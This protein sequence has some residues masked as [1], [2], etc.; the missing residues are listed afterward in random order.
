VWKSA[1]A[2]A[3]VVV[4]GLACRDKGA[5]EQTATGS[6]SAHVE[7]AAAQ[8]VAT[9]AE[10]SGTVE[11]RRKGEVRW[12]RVDVGATFRER[13]WVRTGANSFARLR[14]AT[15]GFLDLGENT[16]VLV[17][18]SVS[19]ESGSVV[20]IAEGAEPIRVNAGDGSEAR[21]AA[22]PGGP[23]EFRLTPSGTG[24]EI[25]VIKG[26]LEV[27]TKDGKRIVAA[28]QATDV[29]QQ[30]TSEVVQL[31]PFP[32]S[33]SPGVDARFKFGAG[34]RIPLAWTEVPGAAH[35]HLQIARDTE[36]HNLVMTSETA[37]T[38]GS[39]SPDAE[40]LYVWR[41]AARDASGR[42]G[43][44]GFAR[45]LYCESGE[46]RDLLIGPRD[47]FKIEF[48]S[49]PPAV[50]F[51]W[52]SMGDIK[53]YKLIIERAPGSE[54]V[55][56]TVTAAQQLSVTLDEGTYVWG[57]YAIKPND[58]EEPIFLTLRLLTIHK[59]QGPKIHTEVH[60]N[61]PRP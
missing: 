19:V 11:V 2:L 57:V 35:Y 39:F 52:R 45:R 30:R 9:S 50:E 24:L 3:V 25:A 22:A 47:G 48:P 40:G 38:N 46:P 29:A 60:W 33:L 13:D 6:G 8:I 1:I 18:S 21:I 26:N 41:V 42:L 23:A 28:G 44:Y 10:T 56:S 12:E 54:P 36:F 14:F 58:E 17:D 49:K 4:V 15:H 51:S 16:T 32:K 20:G 43:E 34:L 27:T 53:K 5:G 7:Q 55:V 59:Q 37:G 61:Q 31:L